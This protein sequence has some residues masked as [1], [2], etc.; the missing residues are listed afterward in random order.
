[1]AMLQNRH[2]IPFKI[3]QPDAWTSKFGDYVEKVVR[4]LVGVED[5][6]VVFQHQMRTTSTSMSSLATTTDASDPEEIRIPLVALASVHSRGWFRRKVTITANDMRLLAQI[7]GSDGERIVLTF[8][9]RDRHLA[10]ELVTTLQFKLSDLGMARLD[11]QIQ[12]LEADSVPML[13]DATRESSKESD[14]A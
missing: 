14:S 11:D 12:R 2:R 6:T 5:D 10:D 8:G 4:G 13:P 7:P 9:W 3:P 1:M